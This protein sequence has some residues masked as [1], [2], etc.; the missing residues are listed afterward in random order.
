MFS[1][2]K[3]SSHFPYIILCKTCDPGQA[4]FWPQVHNLS[5]LDRGQLDDATNQI[6]RLY[7]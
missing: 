3:I 2:K 4:H 6:S 5:E 7:Y 1:D